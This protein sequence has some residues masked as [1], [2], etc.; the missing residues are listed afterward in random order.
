MEIVDQRF[1]GG[2]VAAG[3]VENQV[4]PFAAVLQTVAIAHKA[5]L[6]L[7]DDSEVSVLTRPR[8]FLLPTAVVEN[9]VAASLLV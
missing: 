5:N 4:E 8:R 6:V 7:I 1:R 3:R 2:D 9:R